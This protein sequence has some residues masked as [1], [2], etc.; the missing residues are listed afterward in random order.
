M[1]NQ[2]GYEYKKNWF[3][4]NLVAIPAGIAG[5]CSACVFRNALAYC[6][7]MSCTYYDCEHDFIESV[8]WC[9]TQTHANIGMWTELRNFFDTTPSPQIREIS[10]EIVTTS[11]LEKIQKSR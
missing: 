9:G 4:S 5:N 2:R 6:K 10:N 7:N 11:V 8:Y 3:K 1:A